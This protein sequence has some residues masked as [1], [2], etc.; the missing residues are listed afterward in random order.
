MS[1]VTETEVRA[2][3]ARAKTPTFKTAGTLLREA[4]DTSR[5][6]FDVFLSHSYMD[7]ELVLG[8]K[9]LLEEKGLTV[10]VDWIDDPL[11]DR[12]E[13]TRAT[14]EKIRARMRQCRSLLYLHSANATKS[15]WC[16]WELGYF[17]AF[18]HPSR[19]VFI[20][21]VTAAD[22][23][24]TSQEY[25]NLYDTVDMASIGVATRRRDDIKVKDASGS[26]RSWSV[27]A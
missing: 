1:Y 16:P 24:Y 19:R 5:S 10:Y 22:R 6:S 17:D 11:L 14:A 18:T 4:R 20:F 26:F 21:P 13:V 9:Q 27:A 12:R 2:A 8:A 7:Q 3:A 23:A 15:K 25:L